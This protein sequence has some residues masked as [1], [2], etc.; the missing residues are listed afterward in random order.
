MEHCLAGGVASSDD[1]HLLAGHRRRLGDGRAIEDSAAD[2]SFELRD[3]DA[4][5][6]DAGGDHGRVGPHPA[7]VG[8]GQ[9]ML[10]VFGPQLH[11]LSQEDEFGAER[12]RLLKGAKRE[13][14]TAHAPSETG[15]VADQ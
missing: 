15:I 2:Q 5:I 14:R 1:E 9:H 8:E 11:D 10:P 13:V 12:P 7:P 3:T 4:A 6:A